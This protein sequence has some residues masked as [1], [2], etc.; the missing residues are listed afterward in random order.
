MINRDTGIVCHL[1]TRQ[2][3][4]M[5]WFLYGKKMKGEIWVWEIGWAEFC[6]FFS[7][8]STRQEKQMVW[9]LY[10]KKNEG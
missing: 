4:Q 9:F 6:V 2:E 8:C 3:K 1:S 7:K 10:G 5:V